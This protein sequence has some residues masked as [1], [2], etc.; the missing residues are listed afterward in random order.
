MSSIIRYRFK[1]D[2][3]Y[4]SVKF[5]GASCSLGELK[6]LIMEKCS[7]S[8]HPKDDYELTISDSNSNEEYKDH[9][10]LIPRNTSVV[11]ARKIRG[12]VEPLTPLTN[13]NN[14]ASSDDTAG[15]SHQ[16]QQM[17]EDE[18]I[19]EI[20]KGS[21][22]RFTSSHRSPLSTSTS[23][24]C[25]KCNQQG[26][27]KPTCPLNSMNES[28]KEHHSPYQ[29]NYSA[30]HGRQS[31]YIRE[32]QPKR[33]SG[34]PRS[35]LISVP[36]HIPG[37]LRDQTG[38]FVIPKQTAEALVEKS[39]RKHE[40]AANRLRQQQQ[41][42]SAVISTTSS[43]TLKLNSSSKIEDDPI[44]HDLLCPLCN[45]IYVDAVITPCCNLS[46]C[47]ECVRT[48][49]VES[50]EHE[51]PSCHR[52]HVPIDQINPNLFL[53]NHVQR[54]LSEK[55]QQ[56]KYAL[57]SSYSVSTTISTSDPDFDLALT[58]SNESDF[59]VLGGSSQQQS[60]VQA[61]KNVLT[62]KSTTTITNQQVKKSPSPQ[63]IFA[64][65][66]ADM[67]FEDGKQPDGPDG[68][69]T[70]T[71]VSETASTAVPDV[72]LMD[73][74]DP[75]QTTLNANTTSTMQ[76]VI[77]AAESSSQPSSEALLSNQ[78]STIL[79]SPSTTTTTTMSRSTMSQQQTYLQPQHPPY[80]PHANN[81][82][83]S[84]GQLSY[85]YP[86]V[87]IQSTIYS[88]RQMIPLPPAIPPYAAGP[89]VGRPG[90][91]PYAHNY[92][93]IPPHLP[94]HQTHPMHQLI[95]STLLP[96][97]HPAHTGVYQPHPHVHHPSAP[98]Q[99]FPPQLNQ[100]IAPA[101]TSTSASATAAAALLSEE[102]FYREK[103]RLLQQIHDR[104]PMRRRSS[105]A[106]S[107]SSPAYRR[108]SNYR[109]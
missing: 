84:Y 23:Y 32:P 105:S 91:P 51:C 47:D 8:H 98:T 25:H 97:H 13:N 29:I 63:P 55:Q 72:N 38:S 33:T 24:V 14:T 5:D 16:S 90:L 108:Y 66:P 10:D 18:R 52:Q 77:E 67:T 86:S 85:A 45:K 34:L 68:H 7:K 2:K 107:P 99:H 12:C 6:R 27:H 79:S 96:G 87:S 17:T 28:G 46:F 31:G 57:P 94:P 54:W 37:S 88:P 109:R 61:T 22:T 15:G 3:N 75:S 73:T 26:Q 74:T 60:T 1:A 35:E 92:P 43:S 42:K 40:Q 50:E 76:T 59:D 104:R 4:E 64:T 78:S 58:T 71:N 80:A 44:P 11:V 69:Q 56:Q 101:V 89:F 81:S 9:N 39:E 53:R 49:L 100:T 62:T 65:R 30:H 41:T 20:I 103:Q 102:E 106:R 70:I 36:R 95:Q 93:Q 82:Y 83:Q 19:K 48:S 21:Q